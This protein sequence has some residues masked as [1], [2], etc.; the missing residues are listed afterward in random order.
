M[1]KYLKLTRDLLESQR[2]VMTLY[3]LVFKCNEVNF[4][5]S[6]LIERYSNFIDEVKRYNDIRATLE[7]EY[8]IVVEDCLKDCIIE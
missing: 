8:G 3:S 2:M 4:P 6:W 7:K 5:T 1:K